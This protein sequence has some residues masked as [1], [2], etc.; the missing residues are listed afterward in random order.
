MTAVAKIWFVPTINI[1]KIPIMTN[2]TFFDAFALLTS[3]P[4]EISSLLY[5]SIYMLLATSVS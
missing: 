1:F 4:S 3:I 5:S 2:I